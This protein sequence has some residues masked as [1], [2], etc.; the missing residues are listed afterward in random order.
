MSDHAPALPMLP[1]LPH[2]RPGALRGAFL[3]LWRDKFA[4]A[5]ALFLVLLALTAIVG[6][7]L[8]G[9]EALAINLRGRN[10]GPFSGQGGWLYVLGADS[11]GRSI[12]ARLIVGSRTTLSIAGGAVLG[13]LM[14]G[15]AL[16]FVAGFARGALSS[17]ILR[18]ADVVM[19][20][21]SL[22]LALIVL[23]VLEPRVANVVL[24][25]IVS[26]I[27]IYLRTARAETLEV[28]ERMFVAAARV[29]GA[30]PGRLVRRHVM[31]IVLPTLITVATLEFA[32]V[33]LSESSLSFLGLGVQAPGITWGLMVADGRGTLG[34]AWWRSFWP[35]LAITLTAISINLVANWV[36]VLTDP[37]Q[38][39]RLEARADTDA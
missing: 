18:I 14:I 19:S 33:M 15:G 22:L 11:L 20:F 16:G 26:R 5:A 30:S 8:V 25:L 13:A 3:L 31:P 17:V 1:V 7:E 10:I 27:P 35:G 12:L 32:F 29:L 23:Y 21:P 24:V 37:A 6:P 4:F 36:R 34:T 2:R 38:R 9:R 28:R 39:W